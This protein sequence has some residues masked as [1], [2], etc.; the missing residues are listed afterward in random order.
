MQHLQ[1]TKGR[2]WPLQFGSESVSTVIALLRADA[3]APA[4]S[5]AVRAARYRVDSPQC[6]AA[7]R[8]VPVRP[9]DAAALR[10]NSWP[11]PRSARWLLRTKSRKVNAGRD[12]P[13]L[14]LLR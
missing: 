1:K 4:L 14:P 3:S 2:G 5:R 13:G 11:L 10:C 7:R 8:P 6:F 9:A 12:L